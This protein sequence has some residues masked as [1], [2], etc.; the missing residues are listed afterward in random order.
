[1][2]V[3]IYREIVIMMFFGNMLKNVMIV[4]INFLVRFEVLMIV[5]RS[6]FW[7]LLMFFFVVR[8]GI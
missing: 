7:F 4:R 6:I 5:K 8:G 1:M 2:V 3:I